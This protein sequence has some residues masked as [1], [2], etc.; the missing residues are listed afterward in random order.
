MIAAEDSIAPERG[1]L[2]AFS[3]SLAFY[4]GVF[5]WGHANL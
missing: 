2:Y 5:G 4:L 1:G 3:L